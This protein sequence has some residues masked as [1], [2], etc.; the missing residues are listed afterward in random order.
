M[1]KLDRIFQRISSAFN[2]KIL[3]DKIN[4]WNCVIKRA[5]SSYLNF[6]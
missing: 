4:G 2:S 6:T 1:D 3:S 5:A